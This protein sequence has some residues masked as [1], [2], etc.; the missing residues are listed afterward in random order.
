MSGNL[1]PWISAL[2]FIGNMHMKPFECSPL[3]WLTWNNVYK[4]SRHL[5]LTLNQWLWQ[6]SIFIDLLIPFCNKLFGIYPISGLFPCRSNMKEIN[7][8]LFPFFLQW[9]WFGNS[10]YWMCR[11]R[12]NRIFIH[13][14]FTIAHLKIL[15]KAAAECFSPEV[16]INFKITRHL[17]I[18][19]LS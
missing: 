2:I 13:F 1:F 7:Q 16:F 3:E 17:P 8:L 9:I 18:T 5:S 4:R 19:L 11:D 10:I 12:S 14:H 15:I 6:N